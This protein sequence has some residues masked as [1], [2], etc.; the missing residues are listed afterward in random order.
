M[1]HPLSYLVTIAGSK[2]FFIRVH[3]DLVRLQNIGI[4]LSTAD[5]SAIGLAKL[6]VHDALYSDTNL[7]IAY[8]LD[9]PVLQLYSY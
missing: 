5:N 6:D 1:S 9:R 8:G 2:G 4:S 7:V 3:L